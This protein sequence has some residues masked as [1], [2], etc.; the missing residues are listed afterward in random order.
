MLHVYLLNS[1]EEFLRVL[2]II[3]VQFNNISKENS[4]NSECSLFTF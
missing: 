3:V 2:E 4:F 1:L